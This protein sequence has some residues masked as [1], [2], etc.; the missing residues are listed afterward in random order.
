[1]LA[2]SQIEEYF[3]NQKE[4]FIVENQQVVKMS[5]NRLRV[6][7]LMTQSGRILGVSDFLLSVKSLMDINSILLLSYYTSSAVYPTDYNNIVIKNKSWEW[8][9]STKN[10]RWEINFNIGS[11]EELDSYILINQKISLLD[12]ILKKIEFYRKSYTE[13]SLGQEFIYVSKYLEAKEIIEKNIFDDPIL[14]YPYVSGYANLSNATLQDTAKEIVL[15]WQIQ[16]GF[17]SET[18]NLRI[19]YTRIIREEKE[20][21]NLKSI[22]IE[23]EKESQLHSSI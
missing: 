18:E 6:Y 16:S 23:F 7:G 4:N 12:E 5:D 2:R 22:L 15:K 21:K 11:Y 10:H 14:E 20:L 17:L 13:I 3:N 19:K 1:M 8:V 9:Q